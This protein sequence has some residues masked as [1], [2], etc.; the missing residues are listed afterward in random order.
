MIGGEKG[1]IFLQ[2]IK[3]A[4]TF[5]VYEYLKIGFKNG[6][7]SKVVKDDGK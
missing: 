6:S 4:T 2:S 1:K 3:Q 7:F 5:N